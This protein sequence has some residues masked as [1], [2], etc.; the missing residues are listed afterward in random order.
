MCLVLHEKSVCVFCVCF[1]SCLVSRELPMLLLQDFEV[2]SL[3]LALKSSPQTH[4]LQEADSSTVGKCTV[5]CSY[6][7]LSLSVDAGRLATI[8]FYGLLFC[9][10]IAFV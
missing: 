6:V 10:V 2:M 3:R 5:V 1:V 9:K 4:L 7:R 8:S